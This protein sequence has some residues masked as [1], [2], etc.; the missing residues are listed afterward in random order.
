MELYTIIIVCL[1]HTRDKVRDN[2]FEAGNIGNNIV[3]SNSKTTSK[4]LSQGLPLGIAQWH[5][6]IIWL[7]LLNDYSEVTQSCLTL[8]DPV[9]CSLPGSSIHGIL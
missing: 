2:T 9:D 8:C 5:L 7:S 3:S 4:N 6:Q 1:S